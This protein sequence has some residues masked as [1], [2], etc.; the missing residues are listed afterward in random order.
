MVQRLQDLDGAESEGYEPS[1]APDDL[2]LQEPIPAEEERQDQVAKSPASLKPVYDFRRIF[3]RLPVLEQKGDTVMIKRLLLGLHERMWHCTLGDLRSVLQRCG[4][5]HGVWRHASDAVASCAICRKLARSCR[6]PQNRGALLNTHFNDVVQVDLFRYGDQWFLLVI[7]EVTRF[8]VATLCE[9]RDLTHILSA[10]MRGWIRFFGPMRTLVSDQETALMTM[11]AGVELQRL[12]IGRQPAGT[13]GGAQGQKHT[14]TGLVEKHIDLVKLTM[15]K[16]QAE[17]GRWGIEISGE[18]LAAEA[19]MAQNITLSIGGY[20]PVTMVYG[21]LPRGFL[22][23]EADPVIGDE[24][25]EVAESVF[26]RSLRLRQIAL[27]ASQAAILESR[28]SRA[29]R[30]RPSRLPLEQM[31]PG[32]TKV[33]IYRDDSGGQGWRGPATIL[34]VNEHAG[35]AIV[36]FQGRPYLI[37]LRHIRPLREAFY[38]NFN[39]ENKIDASTKAQQALERMKTVVEEVTPFRPF[40][41]GQVLKIKDGES[42]MASFPK[43]FSSTAENMLKDAKEFINHHYDN[44]TFHGLRFGRG[45]KTVMVPQFSKGILITWTEGRYGI[46]VTEHN[47]DAHIHLKEL[48]NSTLEKVCHLYI[49]GFISLHTEENTTPVKISR[50]T[51]TSTIKDIDMEDQPLD[52]SG[53]SNGLGLDEE[54]RAEKRKGPDSRTVVLAPEKKKMRL[55][56]ASLDL[57]HRKSLW[58]MLQRPR[59]ITT[60]PHKIWFE[61]EVFWTSKIRT[62]HKINAQ[63][64]RYL[65][66]LHCKTKAKMNVYLLTGEMYRVDED[67]DV[68]DENAVLRNWTDFE[69]SDRAELKQFIDE[70]VFVKVKLDQLPKEVVLVD[71]TWVRKYKRTDKGLKPKSR[72]CARGFLDPMKSELPTRSTTAT[73]LSQ[74]LVLSMAATHQLEVTSWDISGAFL[75][76]FSFERI[77]QILRQRGVSSP[78]RRVVIVPPANVWRHLGHFNQ[79]F[80]INDF[81]LGLYGLECTKPAY[82]LVDAP[83]AWQLCLHESLE[84]AGGVQSL[85]DENLY[86]WKNSQG[87]LEALATTHVDD[88]AAA[89]TPKFLKETYNYLTSKFGKVTVQGLPFNH[90]GCRYSKIADGGYKID[91]QEFLD[92]MQPHVLKDT[93][94]MDRA[95][96]A[97][98]T[99]LLRSILGGLLWVTATRLDLVA[100]VGVLQS[101]VTKAKVSDLVLANS[102]IKKAKMQQYKDVGIIYRHFP[103]TVP[104]KVAVIHDASSASKSRSYSQEGVIVLLMPDCLNLGKQIHTIDGLSV[105]EA[106]FGGIG[107]HP[108]CPRIKIQTDFILHFPCRDFGRHQRFGNFIFGFNTTLRDPDQDQE[109]FTSGFGCSSRTWLRLLAGGRLHRLQRLLRAHHGQAE[110]SAGQ[111]PEGLHPVPQ[112]SSCGRKTEMDDP[113]TDTKHAGRRPDESDGCKATTWSLDHWVGE[114]QE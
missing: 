108:L 49:Y 72:L 74:R 105:S 33:E 1:L 9:S 27:Q 36:E 51:T 71:A 99:S 80:N 45:M 81:D 100:D 43:D 73:R 90:C 92:S 35:T 97:E 42:Y 46:A 3:R 44:F 96:T 103:T 17:A 14:T 18:E 23:P 101:R 68:L 82:G 31:L 87:T 60:E 95:L 22:D 102:I 15:A 40:T 11:A 76:G 47:S 25:I 114:L 113:H 5:P 8:K 89:G 38:L 24:N 39:T 48:I 69:Q 21:V 106:K 34:K 28:I 57:L 61:N 55:G 94:D 12:N 26:E 53:S 85:L 77:R 64:E 65:F 6:R 111:V 4:M 62:N 58:W 59:K 37:G 16:A 2:Q 19:S 67:T 20:T 110:R 63:P 70:K 75:K 83:L 56:F 7:D 29:N 66:H 54:T 88:I 86:V 79:D 91:Q 13:T 109:A 78:P 98:E 41:M 112:R 107:T 10:L 93:K 30:S 32:T 50:R 104:W 52:A 84:L